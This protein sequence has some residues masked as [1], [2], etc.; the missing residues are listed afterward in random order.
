MKKTS[1]LLICAI[2][3]STV[4]AQRSAPY[5]SSD[6]LFDEGKAMFNNRNYAGC[7]DKITEYK[8]QVLP[9]FA[10]TEADFLLVSCVYHQGRKDAAIVLRDYLDTYP[11]SSHSNDIAFMLASVYF[12][13]ENYAMAK[14]WFKNCNIDYLSQEKQDDY[15]Y[16]TALIALND[17]DYR[18]ASRLFSLLNRDSEK[19]R[20]ASTY[21]LA[22]IAYKQ[23]DYD[24]AI[25]GFS[26][27]K[28]HPDYKTDVQYYI[29]QIAFAQKRYTQT[30]QDGLTL[31]RED[32]K[33][34]VYRSEIERIVGVSYYQIND[35]NNSIEYL[36]PL[37]DRANPVLSGKDY[38][39]LGTSYYKL[40]KYP[41]AVEYL[42]QCNP[43]ND[44]LGQSAYL[45]LGQ[46]YLQIGDK[47][48]ALRAFESASRMSFDASAQEAALYNYAMLL[49]QN[50]VSG[51]GESVT[52]L[53][54]FVNT[55]PKS[56]Y[57]DKVND[58]LVNVYLTTKSYDTALN[59]IAK[60]K[61]PNPKILEAKQKI[62]YHLGSIEYTNNRYDKA[63]EY[64]TNA[65]AAGDYAISEKQEAIYWRG[66][67]YYRQAKYQAAAADFQTFLNSN[68]K[69]TKLQTLS[70]YNLGYCAFKQGRFAEAK[71]HF[72][73]F[74]QKEKSDTKKQADAY[75]RLGDCCFD[76]R[77]FKEAENAYNQ[78]AALSPEAGDYVLFQK[79]YVLGLQKDYK[80]KMAE[81]ERLISN[82]PHSLYF[83][84]ALY[85]KARAAV[86]LNQTET[87]IMTYQQLMDKYPT[88]QQAR[89]AGLQIGLLYY[90]LNQTEKAVSAYKKVITL[91]PGSEEAKE[92]LQDLKSIYVE[93]GTVNL[94]A[95][96]VKTLDGVVKLE[97]SEQDSLTYLSAERLF[98]KGQSAQAQKAF[99]NYLKHYPKGAYAVSAQH[100][101]ANIYYEQ[102]NES[103]AQQAY[104]QV[105][106][107]GD[108]QFSEEAIGRT[109]EIQYNSGNYKAAMESYS[110]LKNVATSKGNREVGLLGVLRSASKLNEQYAIVSAANELLKDK[111][112]KSEIA[113]E[114]LYFRAKAYNELGEK[115][116]AKADW[117]SLA[118]DTRTAYGAEGKYLLAQAVF[119]AKANQEAKNII[120]DYVK[121]GTPHQYWLAK[122]IILLADIFI[123]EKNP[124]QARQWLE[125][126][127]S[128][129]K[130]KNDDIARLVEVR[131]EKLK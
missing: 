13:E 57:A 23:Q 29:T 42:N 122:S 59:S 95:D 97:V 39:V 101:L 35:Y 18:E 100:Y 68:T 9:L 71:N 103:A 65:I 104:T 6:R 130:E 124:Q 76:Q 110:R 24:A 91:Y 129:Y 86:L 75:A 89:S 56:V 114:A 90:N 2:I 31:L 112:L 64:F 62:L 70:S 98:Q 4:I 119:D 48:Q 17:N 45:F 38:F 27:L 85:E 105:L 94:Y 74:I 60:I 73:N 7:I 3:V 77:Q 36:Q 53:E 34:T 61:Q 106:S 41:Q 58:A 52:V 84:N 10:L 126:L 69:N 22:Y 96:Y 1:L 92:A 44:L 50:A 33:N 37:A 28:S 81:L 127:K 116:K 113:N 107:A 40:R 20:S 12:T 117:E 131:M 66:E 54:N 87:A 121:Q 72:Q 16:R 55:Y 79:A 108:T 5:L 67:S 93:T 118:T 123:S 14:Y 15:A 30:I 19:Y 8:K 11:E 26:S 51:F 25:N 102:K 46:S 82:Y 88:T 47:N 63:I 125:S 120:Q 109:A 21:Y 128:N 43:Q 83:P 80:G 99:E 49:H 115:A 32:I 111:S 78:S